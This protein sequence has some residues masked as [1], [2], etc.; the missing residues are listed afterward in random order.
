[1]QR[2]D[3]YRPRGA[4]CLHFDW[5]IIRKDSAA[6]LDM[7]ANRVGQRFQQRRRLAD[8]IRQCGPLQTDPFPPVDLRLAVQGAVVGIFANQ[9]MCQEAGTRMAALNRAPLPAELH[10]NSPAGQWMVVPLE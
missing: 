4:H 8:P 6:C 10:G 1:M 7:T 5:G 3:Q 2:A 9:H